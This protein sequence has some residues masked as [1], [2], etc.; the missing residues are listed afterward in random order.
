MNSDE[1]GALDHIFS[2][3]VC[4]FVLVKQTTEVCWKKGNRHV[5]GADDL[6]P[7]AGG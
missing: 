7:L 3:S 2:V 4:V 5:D 6:Q 1:G